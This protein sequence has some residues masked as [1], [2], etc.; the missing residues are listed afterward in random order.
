MKYS[1]QQIDEIYA[2]FEEVSRYDLIQEYWMEKYDVKL[3][4][5]TISYFIKMKKKSIKAFEELQNIRDNIES[6]TI[7]GEDFW[8]SFHEGI[9]LPN[10]LSIISYQI[11][12]LVSGLENYCFYESIYRS[13]YIINIIS[14]KKAFF[15]SIFSKDSKLLG[16]L[17]YRLNTAKSSNINIFA[18]WE[19][20]T[21]LEHPIALLLLNKLNREILNNGIFLEQKP[22]RAGRLP[23]ERHI[24]TILV[25]SIFRHLIK[26]RPELSPPQKVEEI[27]K[28]I[29]LEPLGIA[30][31]AC[32]SP[33]RK[34]KLEG[35]EAFCNI[36]DQNYDI[37][38]SWKNL[39]EQSPLLTPEERVE[40][41]ASKLGLDPISVS[42]FARY[43]LDS[44]VKSE[45][46]YAYSII[47]ERKYEITDSWREIKQISQNISDREI[48]E[49]IA[50]DLNIDPVTIAGYARFS[51]DKGIKKA[52]SR[53]YGKFIERKAKITDGYLRHKKRFPTLNPLD[54]A[55]ILAKE[56]KNKVSYIISYGR[57]SDNKDVR[58]DLH[59]AFYLLTNEKYE[60]LKKWKHIYKD[61]PPLEKLKKISRDIGKK[62]LT[63]LD[64]LVRLKDPS[65]NAEVAPLKD[66]LEEDKYHI[67]DHWLKIL[68]KD[69]TT[70]IV[71][72][73]SNETGLA[74]TTITQKA[75]HSPNFEIRKNS[76]QKYY[77]LMDKKHKYTEI[78]SSVLRDYLQLSSLER[79]E[80]VSSKCNLKLSSLVKYATNS[81]NVN[82][83][84][85]A[86]KTKTFI[87]K[88]SQSLE[89]RTI[90]K[91]TYYLG[92]NQRI[93][94]RKLK[95][96]GGL[97]FSNIKAIPKLI[98][99][100]RT[101]LL[102]SLKT[103][104]KR[105]FISRV[106]EI[107]EK[108][109][110]FNKMNYKYRITQKGLNVLEKY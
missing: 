34:V 63:V 92:K 102:Y 21:R 90:S 65:V 49:L 73:I 11:E 30:S 18:Y 26:N 27:K 109:I 54:I 79:A 42:G 60:L 61:N 70:E 91:P 35:R 80:I 20:A 4:K 48:I 45:A 76:T 105:E 55:K 84:K 32:E 103:L 59:E 99:K 33:Y 24:K 19:R 104:A 85:D 17:S 95:E 8:N 52:A 46:I 6:G 16:V 51:N 68:K 62:L 5:S 110:N 69:S 82:V 44:L 106:K 108:N 41:I 28:Y 40:I 57:Y 74:L 88:R 2:K 86:Y 3:S 39:I 94:L 43:S 22:R 97:F 64:Y 71:E 12:D 23:Y 58:K 25:A 36:S 81:K 98:E 83:K 13:N 7:L 87:N 89:K 50:E 47:S 29:D 53:N 9:Y 100:G 37:T 72:K 66:D 15:I 38:P 96:R 75:M 101:G 107:N 1:D 77:E 10:S 31:Y 78:W 93:I 14:I 56:K 67:T